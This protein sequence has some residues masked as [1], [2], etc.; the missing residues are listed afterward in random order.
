[1]ETSLDKQAP[2]RMREAKDY[3]SQKHITAY[4]CYKASSHISELNPPRS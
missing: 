2:H 4:T 1:M 3:Q